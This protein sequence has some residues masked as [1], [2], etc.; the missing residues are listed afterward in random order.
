MKTV[1]CQISGITSIVKGTYASL[2]SHISKQKGFLSWGYKFQIEREV[3]KGIGVRKDA[4]LVF[5]FF[6][7]IHPK[8]FNV[9]NWKFFPPQ[10]SEN[11]MR[12]I[13]NIPVVNGQ[14]SKNK[15]IFQMN[16]FMF[17]RFALTAHTV[18]KVN[19]QQVNFIC[20]Y[21]PYTEHYG[22]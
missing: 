2:I 3:G 19:V 12:N 15:Y 5:M 11:H 17:L 10:A 16:K 8:G 7:P 13:R 22:N 4:A 6:L 21:L 1:S 14:T 20:V 9:G 18:H